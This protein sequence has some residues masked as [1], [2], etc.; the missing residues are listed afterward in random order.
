MTDKTKNSAAAKSLTSLGFLTVIESDAHGLFGGYLVLSHA[1]RPLEFHCT[2]PVR[3]NRAQ[4]ILYGPTLKPFLYGEQIGRTLI[5][6]SKL[7]PSLILT[8][9][10]PVLA[11]CQHIETPVL[12]IGNTPSA[13]T[14]KVGDYLIELPDGNH[15]TIT[16]QLVAFAEQIDLLEPFER[17][18]QA[19]R[20]AQR[21][22][23]AA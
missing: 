16:E 10:R 15:A 23:Q 2:A 7:K 13:P 5:N 14:V 17:I 11:V 9:L 4:E 18:D 8:N 22:G 6:N 21:V 1:G 3:A 20:E 12:L 19:I